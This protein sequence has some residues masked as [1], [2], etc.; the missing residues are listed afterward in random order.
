MVMLTRRNMLHAGAAAG[1]LGAAGPAA[2]QIMTP[3]KPSID[4]K[5]KAVQAQHAIG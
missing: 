5:L 1:L 3:L 4:P 2:A